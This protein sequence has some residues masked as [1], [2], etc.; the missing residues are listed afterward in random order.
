MQRFQHTKSVTWVTRIQAMI[1]PQERCLLSENDVLYC[2]EEVRS[3]KCVRRVNAPGVR[4]QM[5]SKRRSGKFFKHLELLQK[6]QHSNS[7]HAMTQSGILILYSWKIT[8][9][10]VR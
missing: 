7:F 9:A 5:I 8:A 10:C 4:H 2:A 6:F 1:Q 3:L